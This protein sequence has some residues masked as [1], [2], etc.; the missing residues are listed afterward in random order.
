MATSYSYPGVYVQELQSSSHPITGVQTSIAAFV[1][2]TVSGIDNRAQEIFSFS[3]YERLY[4]G[5][6]A[7]S[8]LSYAVQQFF[9]NGGSQAFV[10]RTPATS[11]SE[12]A[13]TVVFQNFPFRALG[14]GTA[15]NGNLLIDIDYI[16]L[17]P[18]GAG[19]DPKTF[20]LTITDLAGGTREFFPSVSYD[21][22][23][24][25]WVQTV[26]NDPDSGSRLVMMDTPTAAQL[27]GIKALGSIAQTGLVGT[28]V[29][30]YSIASVIGGT[31]TITGTV[32]VTAG[33]ANVI[34]TGTA[35]TTELKF[36]QWIM[37]AADVTK[38]PYRILAI[39]SATSLTLTQNYSGAAEAASNVAVANSAVTKD[40]G[41]VL[42]TSLPATPPVG[43]PL[44]VKVI[45]NNS[46]LPMTLD[47]LATQLQQAINAALAVQMPGATVQVSVTQLASTPPTQALRINALLPGYPDA[48]IT[49]GDPSGASGLNASAATLGLNTTANVAH[50]ALGTGNTN[51]QQTASVKG[52][53]G[54]GL[55]A[56]A[57]IIGD[58]A[59]FTGIY[60]L[61]K[62]DLF[63]LLCI[64]DATRALASDP[65]S[66]D[67]SINTNAI[68]GAS[69]ALCN[70]RRAFLL[71]DSPPNVTTVAGAVDWKSSQLAVVDPNGAAFFPRLRLPDPLNKYQLRTFAPCGVVAGVYATTDGSRGVWK[72]PAGTKATLG[73]V[74]SMTYKLSDPENGVLNPLGLNCFRNFPV[75]GS[76]LWGART[77][78]GADAQASEWKYVPVRR[79]ALF[80]EESLYR[81]TKWAVFEPND[82]PLWASI[83][84]N[85]GA[86]MQN[87]FLKGAFQGSTPK[88]AYFVKCDSETTTQNDID[89]GIV[90][91]LVG[92]A[93]LKPAEF[94]V[95]QIEQIAAQAQA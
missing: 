12:T 74:Q 57:D 4:G 59:A 23:K 83:R 77:L 40:Y 76:V 53:S 84:L 60:A 62:V 16:H 27:T 92:F 14:S 69:I 9:Q 58:Q 11:L 47:G 22:G 42:N 87:L 91:I 41:L 13:A 34:G 32:A 64:P 85:V 78:V 73:G 36:G 15:A 28:A 63:N 33:S 29:T 82:E 17:T 93:P 31:T 35:F 68:Y 30:P 38:T 90:N 95:I 70:Q 8:E 19:G 66:L 1:G 7:T 46:Q 71:I 81:G 56:T 89:L 51:T 88:Q 61:Q 75:Y 2:Y 54:T 18:G 20:N 26:V 10:V 21:N 72:A 45:A 37:F 48:V 50:Y 94:V 55:P 67:P 25:N 24:S 39:N 65:T 44:T 86:F 43:F 3:D 52:S 79:T 5:L 49:I 6:S 80:I